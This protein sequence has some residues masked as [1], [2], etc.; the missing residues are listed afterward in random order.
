[1]ASVA[2]IDG[3][4]VPSALLLDTYTS[5]AAYSTRKLKTGVTVAAR[6]RRSGDDIEADV[7]FDSN[8]DIS[9]TS[10]ISNASSGTY[11][12]LADFVDH[13]T[14]PRDAFCVEWKDQS[15]NGLHAQQPTAGGSGSQPKLYDATTGLETEGATT[16]RAA[17]SLDGIDDHL[18][19]ASSTASFNYLHNG[20]SSNV[21]SVSRFGDSANPGSSMTLYDNGGFSSSL[22]GTGFGYSDATPRNDAYRMLV[23]TGVSSQFAV[24][25]ISNNRITPNQQVLIYTSLDADN[26]TAALRNE[27]GI[28]GAILVGV[29]VA[30]NTPS[31]SD[32]SNNMFIGRYSGSSALFLKGTVQE[33]IFFSTDQSSNRTDIETNINGFF[34]I[35]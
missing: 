6:I 32:A 13:S 22:I 8:G 1:M 35:Y 16:A 14:T 5:A 28:D 20:T 21:F 9:L 26:A 7:E 31:T 15:G 19:V 2:E 27:F 18:V 23:S 4:T 11:T 34:D 25:T 3:L 10:P 33:L 12:D 29:N 30:T 24:D 17:F